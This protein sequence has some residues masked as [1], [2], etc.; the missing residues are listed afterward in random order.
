MIRGNMAASPRWKNQLENYESLLKKLNEKRNKGE[1]ELRFSRSII[2]A[3]DIAEQYFCEKKVEMQYI[4]GK[5]V[6]E[7]KTAGYE[8]H[9]KLLETAVEVKKEELWERIYGKEPVFALEWFLLARFKDV[10]IAGKPDAVLFQDAR[11]LTVFEY[12]FSK[13]GIAYPGHHVQ[14]RVYGVL[15]ENMGFDTN[16]LFYSIVVADPKQRGD[17]NLQQKVMEAIDENGLEETTLS[18]ENANIY[19]HK[20]NREIA[21]KNLSWAIDYWKKIR[22]AL[23][24]DNPNKCLKCEY[25]TKCKKS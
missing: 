21:E 14:A 2:I 6:M 15:L 3:S 10:L 5:V 18:I 13:S 25:Q 23:P 12:K 16:N 4:H 24:T 22:D 7:A 11:P 17:R 20:F 19:C 8:A 1:T 9:E